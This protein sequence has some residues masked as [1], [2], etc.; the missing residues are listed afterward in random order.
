MILR[1]SS[2]LGSGCRVLVCSRGEGGGGNGGIIGAKGRVCL[3]CD[4][5]IFSLCFVGKCR[6]NVCRFVNY[7]SLVFFRFML[8]LF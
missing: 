1:V 2:A 6:Y 4:R 5:L 3:V 7:F 8:R